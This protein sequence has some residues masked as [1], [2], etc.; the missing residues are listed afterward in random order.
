[1]ERQMTNNFEE[2]KAG[3]LERLKVLRLMYYLGMVTFIPDKYGGAE[4]KLRLLHPLS[5]FWVVMFLTLYL[6]AYGVVTLYEEA[7]SELRNTTVWW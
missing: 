6:I 7:G 4:Q 1:M 2:D 5:W 3:K